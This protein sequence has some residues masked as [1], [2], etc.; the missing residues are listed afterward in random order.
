MT[1]G[2]VTGCRA[3][4][5]SRHGSRHV[6]AIIVLCAVAGGISL[7]PFRPLSDGPGASGAAADRAAPV[8]R[9]VMPVVVGSVLLSIAVLEAL[10]LLVNLSGGHLREALAVILGVPVVLGGLFL[11]VG[12]KR[13]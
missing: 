7:L 8:R 13:V 12:I 5:E 1:A 9:T 11:W 6:I 3:R 10:V 4:L 2:W